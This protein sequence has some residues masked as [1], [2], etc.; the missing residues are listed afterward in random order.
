MPRRRVCQSPPYAAGP[1]AG[2]GRDA[3]PWGWAGLAL[4]TR[5]ASGPAL[6]TTDPSIVVARHRPPRNQAGH[7]PGSGAIPSQL[8]QFGPEA[9][10]SRYAWVASRSPQPVQALRRLHWRTASATPWLA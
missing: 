1:P 5:P 9:E 2:I 6:T 10:V 4:R 3:G 8:S 7:P